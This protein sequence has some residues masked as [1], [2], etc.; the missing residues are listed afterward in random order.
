MS[1]VSKQAFLQPLGVHK[2]RYDLPD[3]GPD[4]Y[5]VIRSLTALDLRTLEDR[6][7]KGPHDTD[8]NLKYTFDLLAMSLV[9]D[10]GKALFATGQEVEAG[11]NVTLKAF[12]SIL[13]KALSLSAL[14]NAPKN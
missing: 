2:E 10:D 6:Y 3:Y 8:V 5:V 4:A 7:G 1:C 11:F 14:D 13:D 12:K 9:D